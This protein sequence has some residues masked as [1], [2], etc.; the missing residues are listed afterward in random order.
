M[1]CFIVH[2]QIILANWQSSLQEIVLLV[3]NKR[4]FDEGKLV[5]DV[6]HQKQTIVAFLVAK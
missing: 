1:H 6:V 3:L 4:V 5:I 2:N